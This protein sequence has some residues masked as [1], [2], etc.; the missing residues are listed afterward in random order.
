MRVL[1]GDGW[2]VPLNAPIHPAPRYSYTSTHSFSCPSTCAT[3]RLARS[4][5]VTY[6][7]PSVT[8][9]SPSMPEHAE[10][11]AHCPIAAREHVSPP[12]GAHHTSPYTNQIMEEIHARQ[13]QEALEAQEQAQAYHQQARAPTHTQ[14]A[15]SR[16]QSPMHPR[17]QTP[18]QSYNAYGPPRG[19]SRDEVK[20]RE[21]RQD[22]WEVR[23][24]EGGLVFFM[25]FPTFF[26]VMNCSRTLRIVTRIVDFRVSDVG[27]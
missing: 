8:L 18:M 5:L 9:T 12:P 20:A 3:I 16:V 7:L 17:T 23:E 24:V 14:S 10:V 19:S 2:K 4:C 6:T 13:A 27:I 1:L 15:P 22:E 11:F 26:A 21:I 25:E